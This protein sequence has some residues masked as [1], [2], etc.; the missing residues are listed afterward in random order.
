MNILHI[1]KNRLLSCLFAT[2]LALMSTYTVADESDDTNSTSSSD[3][4][5]ADPERPFGDP[6]NYPSEPEHEPL[7]PKE[8]PSSNNS[9]G[10]GDSGNR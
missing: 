3:E 2:L 8:P 1:E 7:P 9:E 4:Q 6:S 10:S 5:G